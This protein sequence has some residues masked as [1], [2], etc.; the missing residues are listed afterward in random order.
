[1]C[2]INGILSK[3]EIDIPLLLKMR[4][5]LSHGGPDDAG[6]YINDSKNVG[7]GH[8]RLSILDLSSAGH[9]P[10]HFKDL[11]ITYNGEIYNFKEIINELE[12]YGYKF[13][14]NSDT[15]VILKAFDYWGFD[16]VSR[17]RGMFAFAIW[18]S[19]NRKLLIC[20]DRLG[21]KPLYWYYKDEVFMFA[22][23]I[24]AFHF[25][26]KFDKTINQCAVSLFLQTGYIGSPSSIFNYVNKLEPGSFLEI[27]SHF[28]I[29]K[30][31][32]WDIKEIYDNV[33]INTD[34]TT[35]QIEQ[36]ENI[37]KDSFNLRMVSDVPVG[38]FL[39]GGIDSSLV[40][41]ILQN[42]SKEPINTFTIGFED[43]EFDESKYAKNIAEHLGTN[44]TELIC[45]EK[46]FLNAI[47]DIPDFYDEPFGDSSCIPTYLVSKLAREKVKVSLSADGGDEIF[48]GY[49]R[50]LYSQTI[51]E[52]FNKFPYIL[53]LAL[54]KA[55][56]LINV[57]NFKILIKYLPISQTYKTNID[58]RLPK[59]VEILKSKSKIDF[60]YS[61]TI[62]ITPNQLKKLHLYSSK[63]T[64]FNKDIELKKDLLYSAYC[65]ADSKSYL[66]GDIL[67]K[68]DRATMQMALEGREPFLDHK[69]V[70]YALTLPDDLKIRNGETKWILREILHKYIPKKLFVRPKMGFG[71]PLDKWLKMHL[72]E[73]LLNIIEDDQFISIFQL[74]KIELKLIITNYLK[75]NSFSTHLVW[76]IFCLHQWY[77]KWLK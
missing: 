42:G 68:I 47:K 44:H 59:L 23:E 67:T 14:S 38:V 62:F 50:Y 51:Y 29:K 21:V 7:L 9:Q 52:K 55:V 48:A 20:R 2:R 1:M 49:N 70:E 56:S 72:K 12:A 69:I 28:N 22:S 77:L 16:A 32:Y 58:A 75:E 65:V 54:S 40:A 13:D 27:D 64:I 18:D 76:F 4:N 74:N 5:C 24:K 3:E 10:M 11:I 63:E 34:S 25:H 30:W 53:R 19:K 6:Y 41:A 35:S 37:L 33:K 73:D 71:I 57:S 46:D 8:Q 45:T 26:P 39:S 36:C 60:L 17:F 61:S 31:K 43:K 15:E 66:E